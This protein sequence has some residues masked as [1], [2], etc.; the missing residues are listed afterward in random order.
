MPLLVC[1]LAGNCVT[2]AVIFACLNTADARHLRRLHPA[3]AGAVGGVPWAVT[4]TP[5]VDVVRWRAALPGAVGAKVTCLPARQR[6]KR[7]VAAL[8]G[9]VRLDLGDCYRSVTD[10]VISRLPASLRVLQV[11]SCINLSASVSFAHL[12]ALEVLDLRFTHVEIHGTGGLPPSL[13][14]LRIDYSALLPTADLSHLTAL[15]VLVFSGAS[16]LSA[17]TLASL[18]PSLQE[19]DLSFMEDWPRAVSVAHLSQLKALRAY[20]SSIHDD[21]L[22]SLPPGL[23]TLDISVSRKG[24][25]TS[26]AHLGTLHTLSMVCCRCGDAALATLPPSLV[27]LDVSWC[28]DLTP[29]ATL[30]HLPALRMLDMRGTSIGDATI[31]SL[32][33]GLVQ[34][35]MNN[36]SRVT[37]AAT[38]DHL[39]ALQL[40]QSY[41]TDLSPAV[42]DACRA[43]GCAVPAAGV[44]RG[45]PGKVNAL[46][47]LPDGRLASGD[48]AGEVRLWNDA[49]SGEAAVMFYAGDKEVHALAALPD[50]CRVAVGMVNRP[51]D[52]SADNNF[53]QVWDVA[54]VPPARV[55]NVTGDSGVHALAVLPSGCLAAGCGD[56]QVR[57]VDADAGTVVAVLAGHTGVVVALVVLPDGRLVS[58]SADNTTRVW[59]TGACVCVETLGCGAASLAVL[60]DSRLACGSAFF[61]TVDLW[62]VDGGACVG[63]LQPEAS[64]HTGK[65]SLTALPDGRLISAAGNSDTATA[66][67]WDT[68]PAA[69]AGSSRAASAAPRLMVS[70]LPGATNAL[71]LL[72]DGR[73]ASAHDDRCV[74]LSALPAPTPLLELLGER[75]L[76]ALH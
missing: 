10:A 9:V 51:R 18:P 28:I 64:P 33:A 14:V 73:L 56:C 31:A 44:L 17:A 21:A 37:R 45:H 62:D 75:S 70:R 46:A 29:A 49:A 53:M 63:M 39:T 55:V 36:C 6:R 34:L 35:N 7:A 57:V 4:D 23:M 68:R 74:R 5:V 66:W 69:A 65:A 43:R 42:L 24:R 58:G 76:T 61:G 22:A 54:C 67:I 41:D 27:S 60:A 72:P 50:G 71:L 25:F 16:A 30:P 48:A 26:L 20:Y 2:G 32:P 11:A 3:V 52:D 47:L 40:L 8:A 15:R 38:L 12:T 19:L 1:V 13:T 59:D